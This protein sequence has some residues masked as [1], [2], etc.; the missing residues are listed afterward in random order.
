MAMSVGFEKNLLVKRVYLPPSPDDG[1]RVLVDRLWPRGVSKE[2]AK[3]AL[4]AKDLAPSDALRKQIHADP[5]YPDTPESWARFESAYVR[6]LQSASEEAC[7]IA[8]AI[9][10]RL[11][12]ES[13]T[14]L[15]GAKSEMRNNATA[16]RDW[17][18]RLQ[19]R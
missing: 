18:C 5:G 19:V 4:W 8:E 10:A 14:L 15:Y 1:C 11:K 6:E 17:L 2:A 13:V 3:I 9:R 12:E 7:R 16:L